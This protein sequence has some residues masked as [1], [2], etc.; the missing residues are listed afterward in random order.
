MPD[1]PAS[2][3]LRSAKDNNLVTLS[4]SYNDAFE[5]KDLKRLQE[6]FAPNVVYH[7]DEV[8][9]SLIFQSRH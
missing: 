9:L 2:S 3:E 7:A 5:R 6:L 8:R 1:V 4:K